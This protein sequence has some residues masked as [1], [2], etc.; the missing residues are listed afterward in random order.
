MG[1]VLLVVGLLAAPLLVSLFGLESQHVR[2]LA[3]DGIRLFFIAYLF[4]GFNFVYMT[5][6]Q[7]IGQIRSSTIIILLRSFVLLLLFLWILPLF[8]GPAG[9]W[10]SLPMAEMVVAFLL[11]I[12]VRRRVVNHIGGAETG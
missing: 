11:V 4:L 9:V 3:V 6:F 5:Y 8:L 12:Y 10:L 7:S 2:S 1:V